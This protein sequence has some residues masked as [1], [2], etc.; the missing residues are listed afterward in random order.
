MGEHRGG[1]T[2]SQKHQA[3]K[4]NQGVNRIAEERMLND[5]GRKVI[6]EK[7]GNDIEET[8]HY[9]NIDEEEAAH[10]DN[11]WRNMDRGMNFLENH[12]KHLKALGNGGSS[13]VRQ[14]SYHPSAYQQ[15]QR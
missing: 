7:R 2:I 15:Q 13:Q 9:Y 1:N 8:N 4:N 5:R 12:Q 14:I 10:F 6:K 11:D 3:Y